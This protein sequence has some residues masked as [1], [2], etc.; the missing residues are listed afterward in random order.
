MRAVAAIGTLLLH[1][2]L[3][4]G[5]SALPEKKSAAATKLVEMKVRPRPPPPV[6]EEKAEPKKEEPIPPPEV[7]PQLVKKKTVEKSVPDEPKP[8]EPQPK[9]KVPPQGFSVDMSN[10]VA[11]GN[12]V[13][14][15]AI[16]GGGNMFADPKDK[17]LAPG[18]KTSQPQPKP[19]GQGKGT[20]PAG[21]Y[22][23]TSMPEWLSNEDDR[24]PPYPPDA[25]EREVEGQVLL[26]VY[27]GTEGRV[28]QVRITKKLDPSC[29]EVA[30]KWA[31][32]KF[33]FKP[34][35]L[36]DQPVGMW[37][38]VPVTFVIDR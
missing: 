4:F 33:R 34:A 18:Q 16:D 2:V 21:S 30:V 7:K 1:G 26:K 15:P 38:D 32:E 28:T 12:G 17:T 5:M 11:G 31:K 27:V 20:V 24:T 13:A 6:V 9:P 35:M 37:I 36:G 19:E 3:L 8:V 22:Q 29:D 14:V 10:T 25:K 23:V